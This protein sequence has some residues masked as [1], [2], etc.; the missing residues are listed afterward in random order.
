MD[1]LLY[2]LW[3]LYLL[4]GGASVCRRVYGPGYAAYYWPTPLEPVAA[5]GASRMQAVV[6]LARCMGAWR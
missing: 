6:A 4:C 5:S 1:W 3:L 2:R